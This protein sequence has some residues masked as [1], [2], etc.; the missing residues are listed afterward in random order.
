MSPGAVG[1]PRQVVEAAA[2]VQARFTLSDT[3]TWPAESY[4]PNQPTSRSPLAT[5]ASAIDVLVTRL[6]VVTPPLCTNFGTAE[7]VGVVTL[8]GVGAVEWF[9]APSKASTVYECVL[10]R[11]T[12]SAWVRS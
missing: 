7:A 9:P 3:V 6:P 11:D 8:I 5:A 2:R 12:V 4:C 1:L 10:P